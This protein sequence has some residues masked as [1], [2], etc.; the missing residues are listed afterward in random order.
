MLKAA[1]EGRL[2]PTEAAP[3]SCRI[4]PGQSRLSVPPAGKLYLVR[5]VVDTGLQ[6]DVVATVYRT[7][8]TEKY[9]RT[10]LR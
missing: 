6:A 1:V 10:S 9:W 5:V 3:S 8:K 7:S 2:V 4:T